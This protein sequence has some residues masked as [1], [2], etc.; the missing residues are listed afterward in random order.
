MDKKYLFVG[1]K[2]LPFSYLYQIHEL[3][4]YTAK[5]NEYMNSTLC[6][7]WYILINK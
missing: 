3:A 2:R 6:T 1:A 4:R 7:A 5:S